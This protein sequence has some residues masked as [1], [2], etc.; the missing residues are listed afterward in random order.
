[1]PQLSPTEITATALKALHMLD[2]T[3]L[4]LSDTEATIAALVAASDTPFGAPAALCIYP[5][6]IPA[7]KAALASA[8]RSLPIATVTNFPSGDARPDQAARETA[9]ALALGADE[10][11]V[12]LPYRA[13]LA[14]DVQRAR[15]LL[16][17]CRAVSQGRCLKVIL[18]SGELREP[19]LIRQAS[20]IA[21]EAGADFIKTSTGKVPV[22][23]T[24]EA[25]AIMLETIRDAGRVVGFKA[26]GGVGSVQ[27]AADYLALADRFM[28]AA[29]ATPATFRFGASSLLAT[30]LTALGQHTVVQPSTY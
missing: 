25:A 17:Q 29:W 24:L 15:E 20:E 4:N 21:I 26:A 18:E 30:L 6:L 16:V 22:N 19:K 2:L 5:H 28:G 13:L 12:V 1:M 7:A 10:V 27:D 8:G 23:A 9:E 14:G 3:S 11:D